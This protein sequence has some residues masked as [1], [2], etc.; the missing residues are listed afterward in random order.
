MFRY[1]ESEI[2]RIVDRRWGY[3]F[4]GLV[5]WL[6]LAALP[7]GFKFGGILGFA[8]ITFALYAAAMRRWR[9]DPGLWML[10][11][12]LTLSLGAC[13]GFFAVEHYWGVFAPQ[14]GKPAVG[15]I[16]WSEVL[17]FT[18]VCC[19]L[20]VFKRQVKFSLSVAILNWQ[21]TRNHKDTDQKDCGQ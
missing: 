13:Y 15:R 1:R 3:F 17:F 14:P 4:A 10:A 5:A 19:G 16:D 18:D 21:Q 12:F 2:D 11:L 7:S 8:M 20:V 9:T 6:L